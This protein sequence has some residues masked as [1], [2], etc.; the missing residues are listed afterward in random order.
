M[1]YSII[2]VTFNRCVVLKRCLQE[3]YKQVP[4]AQIFVG[5]NGNDEETIDFLENENKVTYKSYSS[6][7][8]GE[9]RNELVK[10]TNSEWLCF[11]D[12]DVIISE[13]YFKNAQVVKNK[14]KDLEVFGGP[15][16]SY[17]NEGI[18][19]KSIS[20]TLTSPLATANSKNR[21]SVSSLVN[22]NSTEYDLILCNLW[23]KNSIF[24]DE[25]FMFDKRFFRNEENVLLY[26]LQELNKKI[27]Y[28][29]ELYVHHKRKS[30]LYLMCL[31]VFRSAHYR[32]KSFAF[33]PKSFNLIFLIPSFF[34]IYLLILPL[35]PVEHFHTPAYIYMILILGASLKVCIKEGLIK[36]F[37]LVVLIHALINISYGLGFL[38]SCKYFIKKS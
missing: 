37:P 25:H 20:L 7:T 12:D 11:L 4:N 28:F 34:V 18:I 24:K 2:I 15:D 38:S 29:G 22:L 8:P 36:L 19:E 30:G 6:M 32:A 13:S 23:I 35:S 3:I 33:F 10:L 5:V 26:Q 21:H 1:N 14:H 9:V 16:T 31:T 17:L 27:A